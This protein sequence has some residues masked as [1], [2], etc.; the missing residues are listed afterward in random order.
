[1][2]FKQQAK[3]LGEWLIV[4]SRPD[5]EELV[6]HLIM[7]T[8]H[9]ELASQEVLELVPVKGVHGSIKLSGNSLPVFQYRMLDKSLH[10]EGRKSEMHF[11]DVRVELSKPDNIR[12]IAHI[13]SKTNDPL[14]HGKRV[15]VK[16]EY[17]APFETLA[18]HLYRYFPYFKNRKAA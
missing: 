6:R 12:Y 1:M 2:W 18:T 5:N 13:D 7:H 17:K 3:Q 16:P 14:L 15:A 10:L 11:I 4:K 8:A 9:L